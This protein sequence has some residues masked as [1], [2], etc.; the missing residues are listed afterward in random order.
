M[1][2]SALLNMKK[3]FTLIELLIVIA[4]IGILAAAI[5]VAINPVK[6]QNQ[7]K[8]ANG[9][10][11]IADIGSASQAYFTTNGYYPASGT[12][13]GDLVTDG[14]LKSYPT[15]PSGGNYAVRNDPGS[16][17]NC[18]TAAKNCSTFSVSYAMYNP[19]TAGDL[20]CWQSSTGKAQ[21][22]TSAAGCPAN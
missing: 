4:I 21:E 22:V 2:K 6:R 16:A 1:I 5:L 13:S 3:G 17:A 20:W 15:T 11:D 7:A 18:T 12:A 14:D 8:D 10:Q 19:V 9:Q